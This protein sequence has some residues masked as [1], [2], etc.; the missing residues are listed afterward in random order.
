MNIFEF[1]AF[2]NMLLSVFTCGVRTFASATDL[3]TSSTTSS[4]QQQINLYKHFAA[5]QTVMKVIRITPV[6]L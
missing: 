1:R 3:N 2:E 4:L 6:K 5:N